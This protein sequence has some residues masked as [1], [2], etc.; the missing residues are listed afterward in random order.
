MSVTIQPAPLPMLQHIRKFNSVRFLRAPPS[1]FS[2]GH[3]WDESK[4]QFV[5]IQPPPEE[6]TLARALWSALDP[7]SKKW[8]V[9]KGIYRGFQFV[10]PLIDGNE[11][12]A[13][14]ADK[15]ATQ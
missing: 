7:A 6:I 4:K 1:V 2:S 9:E 5:P 15:E 11:L 13:L 10:M 3:A 14:R 8:Y 12:A